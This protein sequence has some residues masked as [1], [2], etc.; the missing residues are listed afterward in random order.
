MI[1][2]QKPL[3]F[4]YYYSVKKG[5]DKNKSSDRATASKAFEY[6]VLNRDTNNLE[7]NRLIVQT[8]YISLWDVH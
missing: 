7:D 2:I 1:T 3:V 5:T 8:P 6:V 4:A